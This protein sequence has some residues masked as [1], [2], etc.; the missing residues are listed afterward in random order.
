MYADDKRDAAASVH[1]RRLRVFEPTNQPWT[2]VRGTGAARAFTSTFFTSAPNTN[3][4]TL[5]ISPFQLI[6][7]REFVTLS[8]INWTPLFKIISPYAFS[9][10]TGPQHYS[11]QHRAHG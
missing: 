6:A 10:D 4:R 9:P 5:A 1:V 2:R 8:I 7:L 11:V 3:C